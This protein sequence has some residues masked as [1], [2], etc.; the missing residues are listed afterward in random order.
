MLKAGSGRP[1]PDPDAGFMMLPLINSG[2][3][4][5]VEAT[6]DCVLTWLRGPKMMPFWSMT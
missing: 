2:L 4:P 1:P 3:A 5:S 6:R